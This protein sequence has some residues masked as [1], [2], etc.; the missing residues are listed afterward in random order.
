MI[1]SEIMQVTIRAMQ[2]GE[3]DFFCNIGQQSGKC[4]MLKLG[5]AHAYCRTSD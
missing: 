1:P 5:V 2:N 3:N 4:K